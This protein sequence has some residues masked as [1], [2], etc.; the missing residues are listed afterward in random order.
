MASVALRTFPV[1]A[2]RLSST[3]RSTPMDP[4]HGIV[5]SHCLAPW[6]ERRL[7]RWLAWLLACTVALV[8]APASAAIRFVHV[9]GWEPASK[10]VEQRFE[11]WNEFMDFVRTDLRKLRSNQ[12]ESCPL[13]VLCLELDDEEPARH[14]RPGD[15]GTLVTMMS[16]SRITSRNPAGEALRAQLFWGELVMADVQGGE[17]IARA[18]ARHAQRDRDGLRRMAAAAR[19]VWE[20]PPEPF[21]FDRY[22][23]SSGFMSF[24]RGRDRFLAYADEPSGTI[25]NGLDLSAWVPAGWRGLAAAAH[26]PQTPDPW[27]AGIMLY[28]RLQGLGAFAQQ[29]PWPGPGDPFAENQFGAP[30]A[31]WVP[32]QASRTPWWKRPIRFVLRSIKP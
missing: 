30:R 17:D 8:A 6:R 23:M 22:G 32:M 5:A 16:H 7:P 21:D 3:V 13:R 15:I 4:Q 14:L 9:M 10:R 11:T 24:V 31:W 12:T 29:E 27:Q 26:G 20:L 2:E 1:A 28:E 19:A 18:L 25:S